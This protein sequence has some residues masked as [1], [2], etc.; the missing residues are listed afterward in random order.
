MDLNY[1]ILKLSSDGKRLIINNLKLKGYSRV[2][3]DKLDN[4]QNADKLFEN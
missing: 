2:N 4:F 3:E 1:A